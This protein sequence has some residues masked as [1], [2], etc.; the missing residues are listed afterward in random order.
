MNA[1]DMKY[2]DGKFDESKDFMA[3]LGER[4]RETETDI[5]WIK[6]IGA[7]FA[8]IMSTIII[9]LVIAFVFSGCADPGPSSSGGG[10]HFVIADNTQDAPCCDIS[11]NPIAP[12]IAI[13]GIDPDS[14]IPEWENE[15]TSLYYDLDLD[16]RY[17]VSWHCAICDD[18]YCHIEAV[19][20][21]FDGDGQ[22]WVLDSE[23]V[24]PHK[25]DE[26]CL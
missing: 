6:K 22:G 8:G 25:C 24:G 7:F 17:I 20:I 23:Y 4:V 21:D 9:A 18:G 3:K 2:L 1:E 26:T 14:G 13:H 10:A 15:T 5:S 11:C 16:L 12:T 19:Y